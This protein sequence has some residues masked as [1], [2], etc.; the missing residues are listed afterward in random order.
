MVT[1]DVRPTRA[2]FV[3]MDPFQGVPSPMAEDAPVLLPVTTMVTAVCATRG[4]CVDPFQALVS[5]TDEDA[6]VL[7]EAFSPKVLKRKHRLSDENL[8]QDQ[9]LFTS[10]SYDPRVA[11][12]FRSPLTPQNLGDGS[13]VPFPRRLLFSG[14]SLAGWN[15]PPTGTPNDPSSPPAVGLSSCHALGLSSPRAHG[16][17]TLHTLGLPFGALGF[18]SPQAQQDQTPSP[19]ATLA[20]SLD[21]M[22]HL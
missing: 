12:E 4:T 16:P 2:T 6:P 5:P 15:L 17:S 14:D 10:A 11:K 9:D 20:S 3:K 21:Q 1:A 19:Q 8:H 13:P 22:M 18:P 7:L